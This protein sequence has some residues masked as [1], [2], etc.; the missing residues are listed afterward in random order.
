MMKHHEKAAKT[1]GVS[2]SERVNEGDGLRRRLYVSYCPRSNSK[3][4]QY[5]SGVRKPQQNR[6]EICRLTRIF[7]TDRDEKAAKA[8]GVRQTSILMPG[9]MC[10]YCPNKNVSLTKYPSGFPASVGD[11]YEIF[12]LTRI[13]H[14]ESS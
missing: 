8:D 13:F 11:W 9:C 4:T 12:G 2:R 3:L 6:Y 10:T 1:Y 5:P 7:H 14:N